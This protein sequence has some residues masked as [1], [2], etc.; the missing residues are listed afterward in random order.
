M[1]ESVI[2]EGLI[3]KTE[4]FDCKAPMTK[5]VPSIMRYDAVIISKNGK[6]FGMIDSRAV[7][8]SMGL[9]VS[10]NQGVEKFV[11]KVPRIKDSTSMDDAIYYFYKAR[12]KALPYMKNE[13]IKGILKR[14]TMLKVLL[15]LN[16]LGQVKVEDAMSSPL[17]AMDISSTVSQAKAI[18]KQN[19]IN[20]LGVLNGERLFGIVTNY[21]LVDRFTMN[22]E[23]LPERRTGIYNPSNISLKDVAEKNPVSVEHD[24]SLSDA[25][26]LLVERNISSLV[27]TK[28]GKPIGVL[29]ELDILEST[30]AKGQSGGNKIY[31]S[32]LDSDT[33]EYEDEIRETLR[34][35]IDKIEKMSHV[36]VDYIT[37]VIKR[38]KTKSYE[39]HIRLALGGKGIVNAHTSGFLLERTLS[40]LLSTLRK[41]ITKNKEKYMA[42]KKVSSTKGEEEAY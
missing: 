31:V 28:S 16:K 14:S 26:R 12:V 1:A 41:G 22:S 33:Y 36:N 27:V 4:F 24:S 32:G 38:V 37:L 40:G 23:R 17:I 15:S 2:P 34:S 9:N 18:M 3:S 30:M 11:L 6:Y 21:D 13:R 29:T 10:P 19:K 8:K 5:V 20:R 25:T 39:L 42:I 7:Y 35:F